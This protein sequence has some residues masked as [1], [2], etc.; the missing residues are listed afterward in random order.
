MSVV[1]KSKLDMDQLGHLS[2]GQFMILYSIL[3]DEIGSFV[4]LMSSDSILNKHFSFG[5]YST[6]LQFR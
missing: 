1:I 3:I 6:L 5:I 2:K 4:S